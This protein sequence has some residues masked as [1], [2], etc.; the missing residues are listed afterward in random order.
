MF[1]SKHILAA[2]VQSYSHRYIIANLTA[3]HKSFEYLKSNIFPLIDTVL[4]TYEYLYYI[5]I[6]IYIYIQVPAMQHNIDQLINTYKRTL[7]YI[8]TKNKSQKLT[9]L[10]K[11]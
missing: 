11:L 9:I 1:F 2:A 10:F 5:Y 8:S 7:L 6:Y 4:L 3:T